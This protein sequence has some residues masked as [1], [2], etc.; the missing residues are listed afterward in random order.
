MTASTWVLLL[1][2]GSSAGKSTLARAILGQ[3]DQP[4][5][6]IEADAGY[7]ALSSEVTSA[8]IAPIVVFHR[9]VLTWLSAGYCVILDGSL[10]Y[11]DPDLRRQCLDTLPAGRAFVAGVGCEV[12]E[13]R[14]REV[15]R[16]EV[17][18]VGWAEQQA[19]D[20]NDGV[21]LLINVDTT[22]GSADDHGRVVLAALHEALS[23]LAPRA[24]AAAGRS[25]T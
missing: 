8:G 7:P 6:L 9:S 21:D 11:G 3:V 1:S 4:C 25:V 14:Q 22:H 19:V 18:Q 12:D 17:R 24:E 13:L 5:A 10:P 20:V 23:S 15:N 16:P 2:G